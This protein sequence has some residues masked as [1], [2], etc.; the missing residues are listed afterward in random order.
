MVGTNG[1]AQTI[2]AQ[3]K[4]LEQIK[5]AYGE[6]DERYLRALNEVI[7]TAANEGYFQIALQKRER[8]TELCKKKYGEHSV[9]YAEGLIRIGNC[10]N[11]MIDE[12]FPWPS[13]ESIP[14]ISVH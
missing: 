3:L 6:M 4:Q 5:S 11:L 13:E 12:N 1:F 2:D 9:Q 8:H 7:G 14:Y 10:I